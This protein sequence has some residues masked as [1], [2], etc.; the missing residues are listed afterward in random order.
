MQPYS[1]SFFRNI[2]ESSLRSAK[3]II[4]MLLE[5]IHPKSVIDVGCGA[6]VWLSVFKEHGVNEI[7][8]L[9]GHYVNEASLYIPLQDFQATNLTIPFKESKK[10]D[11]VVSLEVAEHLPLDSAEI[12]IDS[13]TKLGS[14]ILFSAAIPFQ[15]G[16]DHVNEQWPNYWENIFQD[17]GYIVIDCL[18]NKLMQNTNVEWWY[19]QNMVIYV[20]CD[21]LDNFLMLKQEYQ[22]S[23]D[24]S[25]LSLV[26]PKKYLA[27]LEQK[28]ECENQLWLARTQLMKLEIDRLISE[29]DSI[30][31]ID[32]GLLPNDIFTK[33]RVTYI[34]EDDGQYCGE[35]NDDESAIQRLIE[36]REQGE[37]YLIIAWPAFWWFDHYQEF[38]S[39]I[40]SGFNCILKNHYMVVFDISID[41]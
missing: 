25:L 5:L 22:K 28:Q 8:G 10:Y 4:P 39:F 32:Q 17:K 30:V 26:H 31:I 2:E 11:L 29:S 35:P 40:E 7:L 15:G 37:H 38:I 6:G 18:R 27:I 19:A 24:G 12:F 3:E 41:K 36:L 13:L 21:E 34:Q 14:V 20:K 33:R 16:I 1:E 9:D 23:P